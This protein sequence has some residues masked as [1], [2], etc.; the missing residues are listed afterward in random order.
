ME[1]REKENERRRRQWR[2]FN[3]DA[4]ANVARLLKKWRDG[5]RGIMQDGCTGRVCR[6]HGDGRGLRR[7]NQPVDEDNPEEGQEDDTEGEKV[8]VAT[9]C[10]DCLNNH[11]CTTDFWEAAFDM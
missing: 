7:C 3:W 8:C 2:H 10:P 5:R 6:E 9:C 11:T 4:T 1:K